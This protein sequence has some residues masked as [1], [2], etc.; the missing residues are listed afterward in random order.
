MRIVRAE[1]FCR[2]VEIFC[3]ETLH[4]REHGL[5]DIVSMTVGDVIRT[6]AGLEPVVGFLH[7]DAHSLAVSGGDGYLAIYNKHENKGLA[8]ANTSTWQPR[9]GGQ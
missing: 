2:G 3:V 4:P 5:C 6:P 9:R 7:A 1:G 8:Y